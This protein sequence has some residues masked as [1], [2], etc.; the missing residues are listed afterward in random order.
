VGREQEA[1]ADFRRALDLDPTQ[2]DWCTGLAHLLESS[3]RAGEAVD[4]C[5][6]ALTLD[7]RQPKIHASLA[8][9]LAAQGEIDSAIEHFTR[10]VALDGGHPSW[11]AD[12]N[13]LQQLAWRGAA[14]PSAEKDAAWYDT[15]Y[16][17][18]QKYRLGYQDTAYWP[19]WQK[20]L[21]RL[22]TFGKPSILEIGCGPGQLAA[23]IRD[24]VGASAYLGIDFSATAIEM[25]RRNVP[26]FR[27]VVG[28]ALD[29]PDLDGFAYDLVI[30]TEVLEHIKRDRDVIRRWR[31]GA[32]VIATVPSYDAAS[33]VRYFRDINEVSERYALLIDDLSIERI[34]I[35]RQSYIYLM[36][37]RVAERN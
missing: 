15:V 23:A 8:R 2:I 22:A 31:P 27:F 33:H 6:A 25:A 37:G 12:L 16:Q 29:A 26:N 9:L 34:A 3:G 21:E 13:E 19:V 24:R 4:A 1:I 11:W 30:C 36:Q 7:D 32:T 5:R 18:S 20:I 28:D 17:H 14:V 35:G 10:A